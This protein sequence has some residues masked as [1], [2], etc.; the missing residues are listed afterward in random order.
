MSTDLSLVTGAKN[1][2]AEAK[3]VVKLT[4]GGRKSVYKVDQQVKLLHL[5]AEVE[6]LW[7]QLQVIKKQ[8]QASQEAKVL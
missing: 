2:V 8:R 3:N 5:Q 4:G 7:Q 6:S 1:P